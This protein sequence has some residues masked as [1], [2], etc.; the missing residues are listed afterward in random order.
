MA[1]LSLTQDNE[2]MDSKSSS[3]VQLQVG[4]M[5]IFIFVNLCRSEWQTGHWELATRLFQAQMEFSNW[6]I[7]EI[8]NNYGMEILIDSCKIDMF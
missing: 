4:L 5:D 6:A 1:S 3:L 7:S 2:S 8:A